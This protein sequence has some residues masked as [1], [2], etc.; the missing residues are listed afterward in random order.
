MSALI[1]LTYDD[2]LPVHCKFVAPLL[3]ERGLRGTFYIPAARDDLHEY[4]DDWRKAAAMGHELGNHSSFIPAGPAPNG[5][6]SRL[7]A[8]RTTTVS[9]SGKN[10]C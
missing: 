7:I 1:C 8:W 3:A 4:L 2:A 6:G 9:A 5:I 10:C